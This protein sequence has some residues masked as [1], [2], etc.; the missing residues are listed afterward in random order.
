MGLCPTDHIVVG[1]KE[2]PEVCL[3]LDKRI[4]LELA[5]KRR[6]EILQAT[7][8]VSVA[9][10][11]VAAQ[12]A[13]QWLAFRV[14][15]FA[16]GSDLHANPLPAGSFDNDYR[17]GAVG[18]EMPVTINGSKHD[19]VSIA[20]AYAGRADTVLA[21][22]K[23]LI[24]LETDQAFLRWVEASKKLA[25]YRVALRAAQERADESKAL[26]R[27]PDAP[28][29]GP[30]GVVTISRLLDNGGLASQMRAEVNKARYEMLLALAQLERVTAGGFCARLDTAPDR[31]DDVAAAK[32]AAKA[33]QK[34]RAEEKK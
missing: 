18:P 28:G 19:R 14:N 17:P 3:L 32:A 26:Y 34:R 15:T 33:M 11:E 8:G 10:L 20:E 25:M 21:R 4:L 23:L 24:G 30:G 6:P 12:Q 31:P 29:G 22:T 13:P 1:R 27:D 5:M 7:L 9:Q 16:S 2:L